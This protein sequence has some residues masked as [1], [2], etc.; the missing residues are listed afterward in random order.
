MKPLYYLFISLIFVLSC[1]KNNNEKSNQNITGKWKQ[2]A[3][4]NSNGGSTPIWNQVDNGYTIEFLNNGK[5]ISTKHSE[6]T[7]GDFILTTNNQISMTYN[8]SSFKNNF[9]EAIEMNT[10]SELV[11]KPSYKECDEGCSVKFIK[12]K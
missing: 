1:S 8:C 11:L 5:F 12:I 2:V 7:T 4:Y 10:I 9:I 6:C 3:F